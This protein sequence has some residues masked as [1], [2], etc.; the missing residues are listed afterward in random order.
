MV[1]HTQTI[2][3]LVPTN[4]L[5]VFDHFVR[6]AFKGLKK[7]WWE[8]STKLKSVLKPLSILV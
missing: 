1:K 6:L 7:S 3:R 5:S 4:I 8:E 2:R